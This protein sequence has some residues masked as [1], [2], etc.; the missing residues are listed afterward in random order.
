MATVTDRKISSFCDEVNK[1]LDN[2][3]MRIE[4]LRKDL[5]KTY[6]A[7]SDIFRENE[8]HLVELAD[9]IEAKLQLV[10]GNCSIEWKGTAR[11]E[12]AAIVGE[13]VEFV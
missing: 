11:L 13:D 4:V 8:R 5:R 7:E 9:D 2:M 6:G 12:K 1:E 10:T 3:K